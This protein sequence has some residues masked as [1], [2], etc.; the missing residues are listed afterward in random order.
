[1]VQVIE[2]RLIKKARKRYRCDSCAHI[3]MFSSFNEVANQ[4]KLSFTEKRS[5]VEA[6]QS[7]QM[8]DIGEPY[9]RQFNKMD[10][11]TYVWRAIPEIHKICCKYNL[12]SE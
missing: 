9:I 6:K 1:M 4:C 8:I 7:F 2:E 3:N 10:G 11:E 12:Y 5:L